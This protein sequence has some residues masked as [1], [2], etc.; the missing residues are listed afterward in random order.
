[1]SFKADSP[2]LAHGY[3]ASILL[4]LIPPWWFNTM[5]KR[6]PQT[7]GLV[8]ASATIPAR[9]LPIPEIRYYLS[10][11]PWYASG[12]R[13]SWLDS[14]QITDHSNRKAGQ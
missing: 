9:H 6:L 4:S 3:P 1:M 11:H 8:T 12:T 13:S 10:S 5:D 14:G 7:I 2:K